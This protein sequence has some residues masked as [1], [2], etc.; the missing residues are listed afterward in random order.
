VALSVN[1]FLSPRGPIDGR[2]LFPMEQPADVVARLNEYLAQGNAKAAVYSAATATQRDD[3]AYAWVLYRTYDAVL[4]RLANTPASFSAA[5]EGSVTFS[6]KQIAVMEAKRDE[7][8]AEY[9][10]LVSTFGAA[11]TQTDA[12]PTV[13]VPTRYGW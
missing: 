4:D 9:T 12:Q 5:D 8:L 11:A 1:D 6:S 10:T 13:A 3:I 7:A 2:L